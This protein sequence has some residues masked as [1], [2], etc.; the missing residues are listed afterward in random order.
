MASLS[1]DSLDNHPQAES[2]RKYAQTLGLSPHEMRALSENPAL[3]S[4]TLALQ[5]SRSSSSADKARA[6][7]AAKSRKAFHDEQ[8]IIS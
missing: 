3:L 8:C 5:E 7:T 1:N 2:I 6:Y 4:H